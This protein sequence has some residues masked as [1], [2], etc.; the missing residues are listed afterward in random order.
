MTTTIRPTHTRLPSGWRAATLA[1]GVLLAIAGCGDLFTPGK[2]AQ[3]APARLALELVMPR[4][5]GTAPTDPSA[6][7][8]R[9][10]SAYERADGS[11]QPLDS[12][13]VPLGSEATQQVPVRIELGRCLS[14]PQ[15]RVTGTDPAA[16]TVR[17][18]I[19][20]LRGTQTLDM[21]TLPTI[22]LAPGAAAAVG[23][24]ITLFE[25]ASI[26]LRSSVGGP[27]VPALDSLVAGGSRT[28]VADVRD[29]TGAEVT[30]RS[31]AWTS[32]NA[33]VLTVSAAG[34]VTAVS[35]GT[36]TITASVGGRTAQAG[37]VVRPPAQR[38]SIAGVPGSGTGRV[39]SAPAGIDC[40]LTAGVASGTC[41]FDF[42]FGTQV[43]LTASWIASGAVFGGWTGAC[44]TSGVAPTCSLTMSE[45]RTAG[46]G[47]T[48]LALVRVEPGSTGGVTV[49]SAPAGIACTLGDGTTTGTC[50]TAFPVGTNV[51]LTAAEPG[52]ARARQWNDCDSAT[53]TAC[54]LALT[55]PP[56]IVSLAVD[57]PRTL[58]VS[59]FGAGSGVITA[60]G[61]QCGQPSSLGTQCATTFPIDGSAVVTATPQP[62]STFDR[63]IDGP[64]DGSTVP[65][66]PV[67]FGAPLTVAFTAV[68][69][70]AVAPVTLTL[71]GSG[72]G[73]VLADGVMVCELSAQSTS[74][75]CSVSFPIGA[76]VTFTGAPLGSGQFLGFGGACAQETVCTRQIGGPLS[77]SASFTS[78][79]PVAQ[80]R[81]LPAIGQSARGF[82]YAGL[83][84]ISCTIEGTQATG[85]CQ[86]SRF[87]GDT[88][89]VF[90]DDFVSGSQVDVFRRWAPG[91]PCGG[92]V[93]PTCT[94]QL[95]DTLVTV[96]PEFG[97]G[98]SVEALIE[99]SGFLG[100]E[101]TVS[102]SAAGFRALAPCVA[103]ADSISFGTNECRWNVPQL[104]SMTLNAQA[105]S[106][107]VL[108]L[109]DF[110][111][112]SWSGSGS[113]SSC[114][115]TVT[116]SV[117]GEIYAFPSF[118][119][120]AGHAPELPGPRR[121]RSALERLV[122]PPTRVAQG[123]RTT[124]AADDPHATRVAAGP[125]ATRATAGLHATR[126]AS[127]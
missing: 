123:P 1:A 49:S 103:S 9:V 110:P 40:T 30:G 25:V 28:L 89:T 50:A 101:L 95:L 82:V 72:G 77:I 124:R 111:F 59:P 106:G 127:D 99:V 44:L 32:S 125:D 108:D 57:A 78:Q 8:L 104:A 116:Q 48:A 67:T 62:G 23:Q 98:F 76:S 113:S 54:T 73:R 87:V 31:V 70:P 68:F 107:L 38:L 46:A 19:M 91:T 63:W 45:P 60:P 52:N 119:Q 26:T 94:L 53:R 21:V 47:F 20:L 15:R 55:G 22:L 109:S 18:T 80:L 11:V 96:R 13:Y 86:L 51:V 112:C 17:L 3:Q 61:I 58:S 122:W 27:A 118:F 33:A 121:T 39:L 37:F 43:Q 90:A 2:P 41:A 4:L 29:G 24:P 84:E 12:A 75:Q 74:T 6:P 100:S 126:A 42:P 115:W 81:V 92:S 117:N 16:C 5:Q 114:T 34:V 93:E 83:E 105:S 10:V 56:R 71:T 35:P 66:C 79:P 102:A 36:A 64:C 7:G 14:D 65:T 85:A 88:I 69:E 120:L 97:L